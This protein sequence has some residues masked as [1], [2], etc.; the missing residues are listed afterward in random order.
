VA[1][2]RSRYSHRLCCGGLSR[3]NPRRFLRARNHCG[4]WTVQ[5][6]DTKASLWA[7]SF[8]DARTGWLRPRAGNSPRSDPGRPVFPTGSKFLIET[9]IGSRYNLLTTGDGIRHGQDG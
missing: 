8:I 7:V 6:T 2:E 9:E 1:A 4:V 5:P 3:Y